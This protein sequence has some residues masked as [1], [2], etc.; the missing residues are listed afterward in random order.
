[1]SE[2]HNLVL[3]F[4]DLTIS[5]TVIECTTDV[6]EDQA[7]MIIPPRPE[8]RYVDDS[9]LDSASATTGAI[10][11]PPKGCMWYGQR[12]PFALLSPLQMAIDQCQQKGCVNI[13]LRVNLSSPT[14]SIL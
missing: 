4:V 8:F 11:Q 13:G 7:V 5:G 6:V 14:P 9:S 12:I 2:V 10:P 1:M 3:K